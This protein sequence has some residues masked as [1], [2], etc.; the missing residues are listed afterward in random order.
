MKSPNILT[1]FCM[2]FLGFDR[3]LLKPFRGASKNKNPPP[4]LEEGEGQS[5][6]TLLGLDLRFL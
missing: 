1:K 2:C 3:H 4:F 6:P 5:S